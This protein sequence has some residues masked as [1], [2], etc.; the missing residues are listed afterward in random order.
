VAAISLVFAL[1]RG[2]GAPRSRLESPQT[3]GQHGNEDHS[4][5]YEDWQ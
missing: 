1:L 5:K 2:A 4:E 3:D